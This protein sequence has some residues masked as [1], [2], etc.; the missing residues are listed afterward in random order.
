[1][2]YIPCIIGEGSTGYTETS[3]WTNS[4]PTSAFAAQ[5]VTLSDSIS[6]YKYI[7]IKYRVSNSNSETSSVIMSVEDLKNTDTFDSTGLTYGSMSGNGYK[8]RDYY[9][10]ND[11]S[12]SFTAGYQINYVATDNNSC[13]PLEITGLNKLR[14]AIGYD[15]TVLWTNSSPTST[16]DTMTINVSDNIS[17]YDAIRIKCAIATSS[18]NQF[19]YA[20]YEK[21]SAP[22]TGE[23]SA[24]FS[25]DYRYDRIFSIASDTSISVGQCFAFSSSFHQVV[26]HTAIPL[27]VIGCK[28]ATQ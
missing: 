12:I 27:Q 22:S 14:T 8:V 5:T 11:T 10:V 18:L 25:S 16:I 24:G 3:L 2:A 19:T 4:A 15:E 13:I 23:F 28:F 6:N 1:M 9:Y 21:D 17:N 26:S 7:K 20:T